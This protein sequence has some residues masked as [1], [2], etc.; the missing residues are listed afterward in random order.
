MV[1]SYVYFIFLGIT[2]QVMFSVKKLNNATLHGFIFLD[3]LFKFFISNVLKKQLLN[4]YLSKCN[5]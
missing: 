3:L 2:F 4:F 5:Y 1:L